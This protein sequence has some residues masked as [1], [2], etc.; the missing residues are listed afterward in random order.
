MERKGGSEKFQPRRLASFD[1]AQ[2]V[3]VFLW[4]RNNNVTGIEAFNR[5]LETVEPDENGKIMNEASRKRLRY[6]IVVVRG[7]ILRRQNVNEVL[8]VQVW[9]DTPNE[10]KL[11]L[12][13]MTGPRGVQN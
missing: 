12:K 11:R 2:L 5:A 6:G 10:S 4:G 3:K 9:Q 13:V 1:R 8:Q 7:L